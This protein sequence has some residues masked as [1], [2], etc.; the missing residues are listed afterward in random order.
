MTID[1]RPLVPRFVVLAAAACAFMAAA[2]SASAQLVDI[3]LAPHRRAPGLVLTP[4]LGAG[5]I[6]DD[7]AIVGAEGDPSP[8]DSVI[9]VRPGIDVALTRKHTVIAGSYFGSLMRYR[10]LDQFNSFDQGGRFEFRHQPS[11]RFQL[12]ANDRVTVNPSTEA[13]QEPGVP[14]LRTGTRQNIFDAGTLVALTRQLELTGTY[15]FQWLEFDRTSTPADAVLQGGQSHGVTI[16]ARQRVW[17]HVSVGAVPSSDIQTGQ[18]IVTWQVSPTVRFE[19]G[20]GLSHVSLGGP[21]ESATGPAGRVSIQKQTEYL[22]FS[23]GASQAFRPS[24]GSGRSSKNRE[25][26]VGVFAPFGAGRWFV[27]GQLVRH[28]NEPAAGEGLSLTANWVRAVLGYSMSRWARI[29][30]FYLGAF[31]DTNVPGGL[32]HRNRVGVQITTS[33]PMRID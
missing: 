3:E 2:A 12:F 23:A 5:V 18:G 32:V 27:G 1:S 7:N 8:N 28:K 4:T 30:G 19:A 29:E 26:N 24:F 11:K 22:V 21:L 33:A 25:F 6:R 20:A 13:A 15:R 10:T 16:E 17:E 31:Q 9:T 14:F